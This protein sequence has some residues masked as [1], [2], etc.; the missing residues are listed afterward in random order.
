M[1]SRSPFWEPRVGEAAAGPCSKHDPS[2]PVRPNLG[3]VEE[4]G[5]RLPGLHCG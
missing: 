1:S 4:K 3:E 2:P 5:D